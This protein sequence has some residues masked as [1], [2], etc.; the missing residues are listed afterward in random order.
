MRTAT[1]TPPLPDTLPLSLSDQ[2][3]V[4]ASL[5]AAR[6][7][8]FQLSL[9]F[10]DHL[11]HVDPALAALHLTDWR[12]EGAKWLQLVRYVLENP[13]TWPEI[14]VQVAEIGLRDATRGLTPAHYPTIATA[15][16]DTLAA[17][18]GPKFDSATQAAWTRALAVIT[19]TM[20]SAILCEIPQPQFVGRHAD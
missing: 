7:Q 3:R 6:G 14:R 20:Q 2:Q 1:M 5:R 15:L 9:G 13:A 12:L 17:L 16:T 11:A 19:Q 10:R 8:T 4:L 18:L